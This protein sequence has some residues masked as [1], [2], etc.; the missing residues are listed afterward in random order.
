MRNLFLI[1][2]F[3]AVTVVAQ[4]RVSI[5]EIHRVGISSNFDGQTISTQGVVTTFLYGENGAIG[6]FIQ[7]TISDRKT[8]TSNGIFVYSD[9]VNSIAVG[10]EIEIKAVF[11]GDKQ[12]LQIQN[13]TDIKQI[14]QNNTVTPIKIKYGPD[15]PDLSSY[16]GML[17]EFDQT[18]WV[19]NN[20]Y[21]EQYGELELGYRRKPIPTNI[22]FPT[23]SDY[24]ALV[25]ENSLPGITLDDGYSTSYRTPIVFADENGTRRMGERVDNL[26]GVLNYTNGRYV[27][28]PSRFPVHFYGNPRRRKHA[29]IGN[30]N[31]K[32]CGF[33]LEYYL[34]SPNTTSTMGPSTMEQ[35]NRQHEKI[36]D[37][38]YEIDADVYGL[39]EIE[40]GQAA[41]AKLANA[42][43]AKSGTN[44]Y[45]YINDGTNVN[46]TFTKAAYLYRSD[47]VTPY[48]QLININS[49]IPLN[50]KKLQ[51]FVL[52]SNNE[53]FILSVN[54]FKAKSGCPSFG[55]DADQGDGQGCYNA[56]RTA[57][58]SSVISHI[59]SAKINYGVE[60]VLVIGDLNAY[61]KE[62]P[63]KKFLDAGYVD[64]LQKFH[65]DS[66]YSYVYFDRKR[67]SNEAGYL[68]HAIANE[69]MARQITGVTPFHINADELRTF[70]YSGTKDRVSMFR[71][72]DHDP[73][74]IG[75]ALGHSVDGD[76]SDNKIKIYPTMVSDILTIEVDDNS[77][78]QI[79]TLS[80]IKIYDD[81]IKDQKVD[82][83][84]EKYETRIS[85]G[86]YILRV[87][88][89]G[90]IHQQII[91]IK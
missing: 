37:A 24:S 56:T 31:L 65:A 52:N 79:Y 85:T 11:S 4:V 83:G 66:A 18:L 62:D 88:N 3:F 60:D 58:A 40:Q 38:L 59:S 75:I 48:K 68:D 43:N 91:F 57:E 74:I 29:D 54:H 30:Y 46:G 5:P 84:K 2:S 25:N 41:L 71:S 16:R 86:A 70:G 63:I 45:T 47:K 64:L 42:L 61:A 82:I 28:V 89:K 13:P 32:V 20:Y 27:V 12:S 55:S 26:Q 9:N 6:F 19:N 73:I 33:N 23:T 53:R 35:L 90:K 49:P 36:V 44:R 21:L 76:I 72:S 67:S 80:G 34:T 69:S 50:R 22:F 8:N 17:V 51:A 7:D 87:L 1:L 14:S 81:K 78:V 77:R 15:N 39:V 10:D